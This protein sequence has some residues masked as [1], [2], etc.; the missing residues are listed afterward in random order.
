MDHFVSDLFLSAWNKG[1]CQQGGRE[2]ATNERPPTQPV[3][4]VCICLSTYP[5]IMKEMCRALGNA[6]ADD[7]KLLLLSSVGSIFCSGLDPS[8][9]IGRLS[10]DR[11]KESSRIAESVR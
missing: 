11:R 2:R 8:Y 4:S 6:A 1:V 5:Q 10:T 7:S 3:L 9:L